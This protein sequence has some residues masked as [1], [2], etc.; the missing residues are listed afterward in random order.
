MVRHHRHVATV[1]GVVMEMQPGR[2]F[3][4]VGGETRD[5]GNLALTQ[6]PWKRG[7]GRPLWV[8]GIKRLILSRFVLY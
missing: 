3:T 6:R 5:L 4:S 8:G 2:D 1:M 7:T